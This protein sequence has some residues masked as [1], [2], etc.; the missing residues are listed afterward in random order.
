MTVGGMGFIPERLLMMMMMNVIISTV[1]L[2]FTGITV[3]SLLVVRYYLSTW[4][5]SYTYS[6]SKILKQSHSE[7]STTKQSVRKHA[8]KLL[9]CRTFCTCCTSCRAQGLHRNPVGPQPPKP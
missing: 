7:M 4:R 1:L 5:Y 8:P 2:A 9:G 3:Q 6:D